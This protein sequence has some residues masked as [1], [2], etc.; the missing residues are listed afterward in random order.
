MRRLREAGA[1]VVGLTRLAGV[2][3]LPDSPS[4]RPQGV[5][6][7]PWN[8]QR[9]PGG[10]SGGSGSRSRRAWSRS[11]RR[12]T[13]GSIRIPASS[14]GLF[15]LKP[16]RGGS[17]S[18]RISKAE[19][20]RGARLSQPH[21]G[22][23][24][25]LARH[26]GGR[27][28]RAGGAPPPSGRSRVRE[29]RPGQAPRRLVDRGTSR[30]GAADRFRR[31]Q[32]GGRRRGRAARLPGSRGSPSATRTGADRH[33]NHAALPARCLGYRRRRPA[34]GAASNGAPAAS[35]ASVATMPDRDLRV[36]R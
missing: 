1:I 36:A 34:P 18:P 32:A 17:R 2:G 9:T 27:L 29:D 35:V 11:L 26:H 13:V 6:R 15:G 31:R 4:R 25:P 14:C 21:G 12:A 24:G 16:S 3:D 19:R 20:P 23:H 28:A 7:N 22:R 30:R 8:P 10:S 33:N 5:T